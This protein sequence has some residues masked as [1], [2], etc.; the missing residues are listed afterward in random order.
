MSD[1]FIDYL[2]IAAGVLAW[3]IAGAV[4]SGVFGAAIKRMRGERE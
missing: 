2:L 1:Q 3:L 4:A